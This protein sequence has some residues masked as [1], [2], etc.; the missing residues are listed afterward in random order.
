MDSYPLCYLLTPYACGINI[1]VN[2]HIESNSDD[3]EPPSEPMV[4]NE[5][6]EQLLP[7]RPHGQ[8]KIEIVDNKAPFSYLRKPFL[9]GIMRRLVLIKDKVK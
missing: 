5:V 1:F 3:L 9:I 7:T 4:A 8:I 6:N 2:F